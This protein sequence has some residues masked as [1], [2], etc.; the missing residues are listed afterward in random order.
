MKKLFVLGAA[1]TAAMINAA[2]VTEVSVRAEDGYG[3][4]IGAVSMR[5]QTK[6][7]S[8]YDPVVVARDVK[9]LE[10]SGEFE[11]ITVNAERDG[12]GVKVDFIV[13]R[14]LR[15]HA[16]MVV[17]GAEKF[18]ESKLIS[19]SK[20]KDG[21]LYGEGDLAAAAAKVQ[22]YY[23]K[24]HY[25][26]AKVTATTERFGEGN[27]CRVKLLVDEGRKLKIG[28]FQYV[29][30][31]N[32]KPEDLNIVIG[33]YPWWNPVG[34]FEESPI[35]DE[36]LVQCVGK[37]EE[38]YRNLGYLDVQVAKPQRLVREQEPEIC[39][40]MFQIVEGVRYRVG[41]T[42][43][44]G[45]TKYPEEAVRGK[46]NLPKE[47]DIAGAKTL[48]DAAHRIKVA[49]GSGDSGLAD[50]VVDIK[51]IPRE[52]DAECVDIVFQV[53]E[54]V[55]VTIDDVVIRGNDYTQDKVI[56]REIR[57]SPGDRM[58]EDQAER[59]QRRLESLDYFSRVRYY[60]EASDRG[61][62]ANGGE[63]RNLVYEVTEKNTGSFMI[64]VGASSVDSIYLSAE[65]SQ[66]NFDLFA[67]KKWFRGGGQ[68]ARA[69][70][71][72]GPR[73]QTFEASITEP[74][75]LHRTLELSVEGY[76]RMRWFDEYDVIRTGAGV[77]L[78]YPVK[79]WPTW[80][81]FGR[82]GVRY[83]AE[84]V[85]FD[86]VDNGYWYYNGRR[87][88]LREEESKYGGAWESVVRF[89]WGRDTRDNYRMPS[90]GS[91][92][93]IFFDIAAGGDNQFWRAGFNHRSYFTTW[94]KYGHVLMLGVR[95]ETIEAISD[96]VPIYD[97]MFLGGPR[98]I[99]GVRYR[100]VSPF[101]RNAYSDIPWG[102]QTMFCMNVEYTIPIVKM[103][104]FAVFSDLGSVGEDSFD[105]DFSDSFAWSVG[106][107]FRID[108][109]MFPIRLDFASPLKRPDCAEKETFTFTV[110]Y[111]F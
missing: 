74:H 56:R 48:S 18:S 2:T 80:K 86:N 24:N 61:K 107:G 47:G 12:D 52:D 66:S 91:R 106:L 55:P 7:G 40:V 22:L 92:T 79:F 27:D 95:A 32:T 103:L 68:K 85:E 63:Y 20:L 78:S 76:R 105:L 17:E 29:G 110:G 99:R 83:G 109:P 41:N 102:G 53:K 31:E 36:Q 84:Y 25:P 65:V 58:L 75:F 60:L 3:G 97:R 87:V 6:T 34:W 81:P 77:S 67:P 104:R 14:K 59:S 30:A 26:E 93:Q 62:T 49:V 16:P 98:S 46:S 96:D 11:N 50:T 45:L 19:E 13:R 9:E 28:E 71:Q 1:L 33:E 43:I 42:S 39:D 64:G 35:T 23:N 88:S 57:L 101:A 70:M 90:T 89:F 100:H 51:R 37:I 69:F 8:E 108:I 82:F 73:I 54:G 38:H 10:R 5:C 15:Y 4:D 94:K 21:Y 111:E 44:T 72:W